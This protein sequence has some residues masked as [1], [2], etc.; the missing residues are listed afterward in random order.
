[1]HPDLADV[2]VGLGRVKMRQGKFVEALRCSR[3]P[4][5]SGAVSMPG[6]AGPAKLRSGWHSANKL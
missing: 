3:K 1:M 6:I 2:F 5:R 4:I